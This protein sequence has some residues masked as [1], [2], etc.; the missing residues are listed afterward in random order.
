MSVERDY[1]TKRLNRLFKARQWTNLEK[2]IQN[3]YT[4]LLWMSKFEHELTTDEKQLIAKC[5]YEVVKRTTNEDLKTSIYFDFVNFMVLEL[6]PEEYTEMVGDG[7]GQCM[8]C[9]ED[10][11]EGAV[12]VFHKPCS[13]FIGHPDCINTWK[14]KAVVECYHCKKLITN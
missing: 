6:D 1:L 10:L 13:K 5:L 9:L 14:A 4:M 8:I 7:T 3:N 12:S 2:C 11:V